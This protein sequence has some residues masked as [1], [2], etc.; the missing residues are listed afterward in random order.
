[1]HISLISSL[2]FVTFHFY[3]VVS[4]AGSLEGQRRVCV[5]VY[6][7]LQELEL[8]VG[9]DGSALRDIPPF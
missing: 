1:M 8:F 7:G 2:H 6:E 9:V 5:D 3:F 4:W